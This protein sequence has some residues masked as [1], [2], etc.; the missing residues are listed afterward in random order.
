MLVLVIVFLVSL[1]GQLQ[2]CEFP[3]VPQLA[4]CYVMWGCYVQ[5]ADK[6]GT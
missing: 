5:M 2:E 6:Q 4:G 1:Y 3:Q